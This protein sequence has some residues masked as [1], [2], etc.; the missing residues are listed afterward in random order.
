MIIPDIFLLKKI[1]YKQINVSKSRI[2]RDVFITLHR[3]N[4][5]LAR[6]NLVLGNST[7]PI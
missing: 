4:R 6:F 2:Y 5:S 1:R 7:Q 3:Y